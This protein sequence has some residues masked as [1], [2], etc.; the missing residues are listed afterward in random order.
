MLQQFIHDHTD[1]DTLVL[2]THFA[3]PSGGYIAKDGDVWRFV[4]ALNGTV[5]K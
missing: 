1:Q 4:P 2:G 3:T 5:N